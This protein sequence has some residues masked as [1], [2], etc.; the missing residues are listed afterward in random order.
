CSNNYGPFQFPEK[1]IPLTVLCAL[2]GAEIPIYGDGQNV[3]DWLFVGDHARGIADALER[4][5]PGESYLFGG[6]AERRN[7]D[8]AH[9]ICDALDAQN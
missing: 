4:G 6:R 2:R 5:K 8:V 1:F 3:R 7:L 9:A